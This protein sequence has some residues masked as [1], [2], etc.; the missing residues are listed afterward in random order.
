MFTYFLNFRKTETWLRNGPRLTRFGNIPSIQGLRDV[1]PS[2][3]WPVESAWRWLRT[4]VRFGRPVRRVVHRDAGWHF[5]AMGGADSVAYK[6]VSH[7]HVFK[8][9][10]TSTPINMH[11]V[12][13]RNIETALHRADVV[14]VPLDSSYPQHLLTHQD[15][16]AHLISTDI[17]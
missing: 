6:L 5:N 4:S 16:Y 15:R 7:A 11:E 12:A 8:P 13:S 2:T 9:E 10:V 14:R 3:G 17:R 1:R